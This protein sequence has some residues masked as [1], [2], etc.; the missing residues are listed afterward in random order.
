[1][2]PYSWVSPK[3]NKDAVLLGM[4][5]VVIVPTSIDHDVHVSADGHL[6]MI[7]CTT[8]AVY[9]FAD[10]AGGLRE[11]LYFKPKGASNQ[12]PEDTARKLADPQR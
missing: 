3:E 6:A 7:R 2:P 4:V 9:T 12:A 10:D 11:G 1:M 5:Q 8:N